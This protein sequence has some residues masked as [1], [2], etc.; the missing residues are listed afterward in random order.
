MLNPD[1]LKENIEAGIRDIVC[2]ATTECFKR[3]YPVESDIGNTTAENFGNN[4]NDLCAGPLADILASAI[5]S[6]VRQMELH[7]TV[8]TT[9]TPT[10]Q[11]AQIVASA[12]PIVN[13]TVPNTVGIH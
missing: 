11:T 4:F 9:G 2:K 12:T 10:T 7:G 5:D 3:S 1:T 13:G 6:Y 8:I